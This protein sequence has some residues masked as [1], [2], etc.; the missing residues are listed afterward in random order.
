MLLLVWLLMLVVALGVQ[1]TVEATVN[2]MIAQ[3]NEGTK[4][5][6]YLTFTTVVVLVLT[7]VVLRLEEPHTVL[8]AIVGKDTSV[9]LAPPPLAAAL[10]STSDTGHTDNSTNARAAMPAPRPAPWAPRSATTPTQLANSRNMWQTLAAQAG[11][12]S[13]KYP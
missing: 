7:I 13:T 9:G 8:S 2:H 3:D 12:V 1:H 5:L 4:A 10:K 6:A 11:G